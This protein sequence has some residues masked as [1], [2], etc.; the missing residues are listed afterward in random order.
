MAKSL[1]GDMAESMQQ[2]I[3]VAKK[4]IDSDLSTEK[5]WLLQ[6]TEVSK[7]EDIYSVCLTN[8]LARVSC[9]LRQEGLKKVVRIL[10]ENIADSESE[11][12]KMTVSDNKITVNT[13]VLLI[14]NTSNKVINTI[15]AEYPFYIEELANHAYIRE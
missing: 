9:P 5:V 11:T 15:N 3:N 12:E 14:S 13:I 1:F 7:W 4:E 2:L 10:L 8:F 6:E